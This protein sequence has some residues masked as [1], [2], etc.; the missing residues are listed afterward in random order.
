MQEEKQSNKSKYLAENQFGPNN[1]SLY[2]IRNSCVLNSCAL[3]H[4]SVNDITEAIF[5]AV[6]AK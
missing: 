4:V 5:I 3:I 2:H 1:F 6:F